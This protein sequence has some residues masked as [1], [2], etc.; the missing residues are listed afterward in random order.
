LLFS[1]STAL[2]GSL[3]VTFGDGLRCAGGAVVR[4]GVQAADAL[5]AASWPTGLAAAAGWSVGDTRFFQAWYRDPQASPCG[6][7]FN[8]SNGVSV[9][10]SL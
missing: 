10:F 8:L 5:G 4:H 6:S 3:G 9:T 1:G 2:N 7:G